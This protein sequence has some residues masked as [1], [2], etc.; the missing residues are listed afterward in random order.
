[1]Y[2]HEG[3]EDTSLNSELLCIMLDEHMQK[4]GMSGKQESKDDESYKL[5]AARKQITNGQ[6]VTMNGMRFTFPNQAS[7][8]TQLVSHLLDVNKWRQFNFKIQTC[9]VSDD[10]ARVTET[11]EISV[12]V[13][14]RNGNNPLVILGLVGVAVTNMAPLVELLD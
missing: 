5:Y 11:S 4:L 14:K 3:E 12:S 6:W 8:I 9:A 10:V 1:M 7:N 2:L 13:T